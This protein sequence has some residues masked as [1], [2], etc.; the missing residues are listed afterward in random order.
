[1]EWSEPACQGFALAASAHG[2]RGAAKAE[3]GLARDVAPQVLAAARRNRNADRSERRAWLR[4]VLEPPPAQSLEAAGAP[5]RALGLLA[6][7]VDRA[8]GRRWLASSP[9]PR[10]GFVADPRLLALLRKLGAR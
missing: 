8:T 9:L 7:S 6:A 4:E 2:D 5:P 1:M 10:P 3:A